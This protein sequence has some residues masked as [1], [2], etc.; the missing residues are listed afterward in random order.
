MMAYCEMFLRDCLRF[1]ASYL[2]ADV[3]PLGSGALCA[4]TYPLDREM[5]AE[6]LSFGDITSNSMDAV[7]DRDFIL[8]FIYACSVCAMHLSRFCEEIIL[9]STNEFSL[10]R[11]PTA[12]LP[13]RALCRR[14]KTRT[15]RS[16]YAGK[17]G[18][19]YGD[20]ISLLTVM[21]GLPLAYNKDMQE[22]KEALFDAYDTLCACL[23]VF[24][25]MIM[26]AEW[27]KDEMLRSAG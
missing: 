6:E 13:V 16:L 17:T 8:D 24:T 19:V 25:G 1:D 20:L 21:K 7:S 23:P 26:S 3:M 12:T 27:N 2:S 5:V 22:D 9:W 11:C 4:T 15:W 18:R 14:K 10:V